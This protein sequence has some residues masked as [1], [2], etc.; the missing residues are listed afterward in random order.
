MNRQV[1]KEVIFTF[2]TYM[3]L[4]LFAYH[5]SHIKWNITLLNY[6]NPLI[7]VLG[8]FLITSYL[9][10]SQKILTKKAYSILYFISALAGLAIYFALTS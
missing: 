2:F 7:M 9:R 3:I 10:R 6:L 8:I 5:A 4:V 1:M